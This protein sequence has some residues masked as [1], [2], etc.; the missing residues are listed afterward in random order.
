MDQASNLRNIIKKKNNPEHESNELKAT[1]EVNKSNESKGTKTARVISITSG[2]G[3]VGKSNT[4]INLA[5]QLNKLGKKVIVFDADLGLANIEILLGLRP[6]YN[7]SDLLYRGKSIKEIITYGPD[8]T[9][10]ISGGSGVFELVNLKKEQILNLTKNLYELDYL[11]DIIIIDTGAGIS[12]NVTEF[13]MS[14]SDVLLIVTPEPT[15]ITDSYAL[16]KNIDKNP[17]F[18][19][20]ET[21]INII[22]SGAKDENEAYEIYQKLS[23]VASRF[24]DVDINYL[25]M[26]PYDEAVPKAVK[27]QEPYSIAFPDS[28]ATKGVKEIAHKLLKDE[29]DL[30]EG[31]KS[32]RGITRMIYN[33]IKNKIT[34]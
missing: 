2:K 22:A 27:K 5:L 32:Q 31:K 30:D 7:L 24:L 15:S 6:E 3:G 21:K 1:N 34:K 33:F 13:I 20:E 14:S 23:I 18:S 29:V 26:I 9:G 8:K 17:S 12:E 25:G 11:A 10:F 4:A 19:L 16:L 28:S